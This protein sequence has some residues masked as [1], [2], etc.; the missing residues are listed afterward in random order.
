MHLISI[1]PG[2][3]VWTP[4]GTHVC[5]EETGAVLRSQHH[6]TIDVANDD[7]FNTVF[8]KLCC[9]RRE[10]HNLCLGDGSN[11]DLW[12]LESDYKGPLLHGTV[13]VPSGVANDVYKAKA[14]QCLCQDIAA[15]IAEDVPNRFTTEWVPKQTPKLKRTEVEKPVTETVTVV[16]KKPT[17]DAT[18]QLWVLNETEET[19]ERA[20]VD[21]FDLFDAS[22]SNVGIH[23]VPRTKTEVIEE[24]VVDAE[25]APV[26]EDVLDEL[27][28]VVLIPKRLERYFHAN[29]HQ[30]LTHDQYVSSSNLGIKAIQVKCNLFNKCFLDLIN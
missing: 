27:G 7:V 18:T 28:N 17:F 19:V 13:L 8:E 29:D 5:D 2:D 21:K 11:V 16:S 12:V 3:Y 4:E 6:Y 25:G 22:G 14:S 23:T 1:F 20:V 9:E 30:E 26:M 10:R 15:V 24:P